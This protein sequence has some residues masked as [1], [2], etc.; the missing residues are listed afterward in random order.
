MS[1]T[2]TT[3]VTAARNGD[4]AAYGELFSRY[5]SRIYNYAYGIAGNPDDAADITQEAFVR[6]FEA[7]PRV[8]GELNFS[9]YVYRTAH[10]L[11]VDT[12]KSRRRFVE[13]DALDAAVEPSLRADPERVAL[14]Q[15]Q[16][17]Q[18]WRAV[19]QLSDNHRAILT[20]RELHDLSYQE[21]ADIMDMPRNTVG[22]L[23]SRARLKFK[24][25][26]RMSSVDVD[27]L[28]AEC[29]DMLPLLS[30][31]LDDELD[32]KKRA[33]VE[34][35]LT[36]CA[37]CRLA[38]EEM[39]ESSRSYR[40]I[41]PLLP[42]AGLGEA[43]WARLGEPARTGQPSAGS[44]HGGTRLPVSRAAKRGVRLSLSK[45]LALIAGAGAV[46]VLAVWLLTPLL[47]RGAD[48]TAETG[49]RT[50][51][52]F[53]ATDPGSLTTRTEAALPGTTTPSGTSVA[54]VGTTT[55][56]T[57][58]ASTASESTTDT[59]TSTTAGG[60]TT[61]PPTPR[62]IHP[63][64]GQVVASASLTLQWEP[65]KDQS[66]V[67]YRVEVESFNENTGTWVATVYVEG[68]TGSDLP[69]R[70]RSARERWRVTA[71]DGRGNE[72]TPSDWAKYA[73]ST[74]TLTTL[75]TTTTTI[76]TTKP[77]ATKPTLPTITF[78]TTT[79]VILY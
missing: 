11:A 53:T 55:L 75:T 60:D 52:G 7:L 2:D 44:G 58:T 54:S 36:Q 38:L 19:F 34:E 31:Y 65:V 62:L 15:E 24:E 77:T 39:T 43:V 32:A 23:L 20:L 12:I 13:P 14:V 6:V 56:P 29:R 51:S 71:I 16:Q 3:L 4:P 49:V 25:A 73:R 27:K 72:S 64:A 30:A 33:R 26:F 48:L 79:T 1:V 8:P 70:M 28:C 57:N 61:P 74:V 9:A 18:T 5:Q 69:H 67:T 35:H 76:P 17:K 10:N 41:L 42:P 68:I 78:I 47:L 22:V 66:G 40:A 37:F 45:V 59:S 46:L 63:L 21:I 50:S